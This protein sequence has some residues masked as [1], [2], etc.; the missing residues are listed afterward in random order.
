M[1]VILPHT[2][3]G[4]P[5]YMRPFY[6]RFRVCAIEKWPFSWNRTYPQIYSYSWSF[7]M[8]ICYMRAYF[9]SPYLSKITRSACI[10]KGMS[11]PCNQTFDLH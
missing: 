3:T 1:F 11:I 4:G 9:W 2:S 5:R 6:L 8:P 10:C 7:Y